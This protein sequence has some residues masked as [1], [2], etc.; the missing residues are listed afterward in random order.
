MKKLLT[1]PLL[2]G[3]NANGREYPPEVLE[4]AFKKYRP[5]IKKKRSIGMYQDLHHLSP[6]GKVMVTDISH[7]IRSVKVNKK[8]KCVDA[9]IKILTTPKGNKLRDDWAKD[10]SKIVFTTVFFGSIEA[11]KHKDLTLFSIDA[12]DVSS[13]VK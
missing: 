2:K 13:V 8:D 10:P 12:I 11:K 9:K 6:D 3:F 7:L 5:L 4:K 1:I